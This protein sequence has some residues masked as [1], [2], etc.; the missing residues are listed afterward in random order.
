MSYEKDFGLAPDY[1]DKVL[2]DKKTYREQ[3]ER[4]T[5]AFLNKGNAV[6]SHAPTESRFNQWIK[7]PYRN[8]KKIPK[9]LDV[10]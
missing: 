4:D 8:K 3:L 2:I 1:T 7:D 10:F 6:S 9:G 5:A